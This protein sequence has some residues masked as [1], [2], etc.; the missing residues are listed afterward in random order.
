MLLYSSN[1]SPSKTISLRYLIKSNKCPLQGNSAWVMST[2]TLF[3]MNQSKSKQDK[4]KGSHLTPNLTSGRV[5]DCRVRCLGC[6]NIPWLSSNPSHLKDRLSLTKKV[7]NFL[8]QELIL[9]NFLSNLDCS[10]SKN[11]QSKK[12]LK[13]KDLRT[14]KHGSMSTKNI[15]FCNLIKAIKMVGQNMCFQLCSSKLTLVFQLKQ[16]LRIICSLLI[17]YKILTIS[18]FS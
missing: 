14:D 17:S 3:K 5:S 4:K 13:P 8:C 2:P 18:K 11:T 15:K 12:V 1:S 6:Q 10:W 16:T 9:I 7:K